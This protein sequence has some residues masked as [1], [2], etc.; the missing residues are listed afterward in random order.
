MSVHSPSSS[1]SSSFS[2]SSLPLS[3]Q[4]QS[5]LLRV[6]LE[7][8][9]SAP[10]ATAT[11]APPLLLPPLTALVVAYAVEPLT[12]ARFCGSSFGSDHFH[13][14]DPATGEML[15]PERVYSPSH[16]LP[17]FAP[18]LGALPYRIVAGSQRT[19]VECDA[20]SFVPDRLAYTHA[21]V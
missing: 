16:P 1:A 15:D 18:A 12:I 17:L 3:Y 7:Q 6:A 8:V 11:A 21:H 9:L 20:D 4:R 14:F 13:R 5:A 2:S 19:S 10:T